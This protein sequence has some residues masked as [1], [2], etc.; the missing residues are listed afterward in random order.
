MGLEALRVV[1]LELLAYRAEPSKLEI[2][3]TGLRSR[4]QCSGTFGFGGL[5]I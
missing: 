3:A 2:Q 5:G 1:F 4:F